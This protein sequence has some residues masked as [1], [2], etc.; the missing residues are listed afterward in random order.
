MIWAIIGEIIVAI[1]ECC[2]GGNVR[3]EAGW[4]VMAVMVGASV[5]AL[6]L[7]VPMFHRI[8]S[9]H[10]IVLS[11]MVLESIGSDHGGLGQNQDHTNLCDSCQ[12]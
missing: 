3:C 10:F 12:G 9:F 5:L 2:H 11:Y 4:S 1:S 8:R 6:F 7:Q